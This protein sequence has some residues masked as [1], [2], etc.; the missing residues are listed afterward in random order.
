[1][2]TIVNSVVNNIVNSIVN[3]VNIVNSIVNTVHWTIKG[4]MYSLLEGYNPP[5]RK[6]LSILNTPMEVLL[7]ALSAV[8]F[9][10]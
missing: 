4:V 5:P 10:E 2:N 7:K 8:F 9:S 1:M 6:A 3:I